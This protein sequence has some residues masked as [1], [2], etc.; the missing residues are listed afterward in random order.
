MVVQHMAGHPAPVEP[1][2]RRGPAP[3]RVVEDAAHG[4][5]AEL[6]GTPVGG[7]SHAACFSFYATKNL[8]I[9]EGGAI[10]TDDDGSPS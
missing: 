4:I 6:R 3:A 9:G 1:P 10:A 5:G 7:R 8:P 2:R